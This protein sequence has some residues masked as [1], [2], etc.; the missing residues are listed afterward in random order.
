MLQPNKIRLN[1][2]PQVR[3]ADLFK[4]SP[5]QCERKRKRRDNCSLPL[6]PKVTLAEVTFYLFLCKIN[7]SF[8]LGLRTRLGLR[9]ASCLAL[10]GRVTLA[11]GTTFLHINTLAR[12][13]WRTLGMTVV[14]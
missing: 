12:L 3:I 7:Q 6:P 2:R 1:K 8:T 13:T 11:I 9:W 5:A 10:T 14:T 4:I